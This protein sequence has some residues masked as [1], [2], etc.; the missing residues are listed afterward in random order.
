M[1]PLFKKY[2][3]VF[4]IILILIISTMILLFRYNKLTPPRDS[5]SFKVINA[6]SSRKL[7]AAILLL[8]PATGKF[9]IGDTISISLLVNTL[10]QSINAVEG[11][12]TFPSDKLEVTSISKEDSVISLWAEEPVP[13]SNPIAFSGGLPSPGFIG[14]GGK[15]ITIS[16]MVKSDGNAVIGIEDAQV[17]ANDG[18]ATNILSEIIPTNI[19]LSKPKDKIADINDNGRIDLVDVSILL[20]NWGTPKNQ[21]A[22]LNGDGRVDVKD[23]S[24]LLSKWTH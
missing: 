24:T 23:L 11:K 18:F 8:A 10:N 22:D 4:L 3:Y 2:K 1:F 5:L 16:F 19:S 7:T 15:I 6:P 17:L 13:S 14:T 21:R 20:T 9:Y 12:I